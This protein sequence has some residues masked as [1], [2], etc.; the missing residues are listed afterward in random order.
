[1]KL[2]GRLVLLALLARWTC[3]VL[4]WP[5]RQDVVGS[6]FLHAISLPFHE[7][8]HFFFAP[9]GD[10]MTSLGGSLMQVLVP[11]ACLVAFLTTSFNPFGAAVMLWW[12][13]ENLVD[14]AIYINDA[15]ALQLVL[16]GGHT[17][18]EVE[19]HDWEHILNAT[20]L[21][22][23]DHQIAWTVHTI[24]ALVM[25]AALLWAASVAVR[26]R[27]PSDDAPRRAR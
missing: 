19:G 2:A 1:M 26:D 12:A 17:G 16:L 7:A 27:V 25:I 3:L 10:L 20:G 11:A 14:V 6:I 18:D 5:M 23:R 15:R 8:G 22:H 24:G 4:V 13:G 21:L 9:F